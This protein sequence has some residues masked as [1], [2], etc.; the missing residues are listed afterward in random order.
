[1]GGLCQ[2]DCDNDDDCA[3]KMI[4]YQRKSGDAMPGCSGTPNNGWDYCMA[5]RQTTKGCACKKEWTG[6]GKT[7]SD[8]CGNPDNDANGEWCYVVDEKCQGNNFGYCAEPL[9]AR[10]T[11]KGCFCEKVWSLDGKE[12][13]K[14]TE[15]CGNPDNDAGGEWCFVKDKTC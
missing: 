5:T 10:K 14:V 13:Q 15:Y 7:I 8:Y 2:G 4:C 1:M 6:Y 11:T 9:G 12:N 3:G